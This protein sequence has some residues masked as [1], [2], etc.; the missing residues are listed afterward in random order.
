MLISFVIYLLIVVAIA[1]FAGKKKDKTANDFY[2]GNKSF[3]SFVTAIS[4][5]ATDASGWVFIGAVGTAYLFGSGILW[6]VVGSVFAYFIN[7]FVVGIR[8]N[9]YANE[10]NSLSIIDVF[11]N[12]V[13]D[14]SKIIRLASGIIILLFFV[15][16]MSAQLMSIGTVVD[17]VF[18]FDYT[19]GMI[20]GSVFVLAYVIIGG[21][22]SVMLTDFIQGLI[23]ISV[24]ILFPIFAILQMG[25]F[26]VFFNAV[27]DIDPLLWSAA[28][29]A[30]G[31]AA[32][33][34]IFGYL[35]FGLGIIG[36]PHVAQRFVSAKN[37]ET[38]VNGAVIA[39]WWQIF[40]LLGATLIGLIA[41]IYLPNIS[42]PE[43]AFPQLS[44][45]LLPPI[46]I[47]V[48]AA[49]LFA[50]IQSTL[51]SQLMVTTQ[52]LVSDIFSFFRK[53]KFTDRQIVTISRIAM[54][55]LL[56]IAIFIATREIQSVFNLVLYAWGGVCA[57]FGPLLILVLYT[58]LVTK[59]G[60]FSGVVTGTTVTILWINLGFSEYLYE[61]VPALITSFL[62]IILVSKI[63]RNYS[64][65]GG[66]LVAQQNISK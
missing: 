5:G 1:V 64:L 63:E 21:Y 33:S 20:L 46:L 6:I 9:K 57:S 18:E 31:G 35:V 11:E 41:R 28:Y 13:M 4:S 12:K 38:I 36:Q 23:M 22:K 17:V 50:A 39:I 16:Y 49:A 25:G 8:L 52:S 62:V 51:S 55:L 34:F 30:K 37:R 7:W 56:A 43:Y 27:M 44:M 54:V 2:A 10:S 32:F 48:V 45:D 66:K 40:H 29:G 58:N 47:G 53:E 24:L 19:I 59:W 65:R 61:L 3:G 26:G 14:K 60:A 15:P 42:N